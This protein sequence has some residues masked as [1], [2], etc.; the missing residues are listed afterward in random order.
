MAQGL[1][2]ADAV[3]LLG[4]AGPVLRT[5]D[6]L[7]GGALAVA[8]GGGSEVALSLFDAKAEVIRLG[9]VV[10]GKIQ[11]SVRVLGRYDR[12]SRLQAAHGVLV[13]SSFFEALDAT[14]RASAVEPPELTRADQIMLASDTRVDGSWLHMLFHADLPVPA[15]ESSYAELLAAL[16]GWYRSMARRVRAYLEGLAVWDRASDTDQRRAAEL[17]ENRVPALALR[18]YE[19]VHRQ[20]AVDVPEFGL[21]VAAAD[22]RRIGQSL[23]ELRE[24]LERATSGRDPSARR[25]G[26]AAAYRADLERSVAGDATGDLVAPALRDAYLDPRF[27]VK[28]AGPGDRVATDSWWDGDIRHDLAGFLARYLTTPQAAEAPL[29]LLGQ[30][31]AGKSALTRVLA[32]RLPAADFLAVRVVLREVPAEA[33][34]QDQIE[35]AVR[36]TIG[37]SIAWADL[38]RDAGDAMPLILLDGFDELLQATGIH[39]SDYLHRVAEFQRREAVQ[40]RPVAV[41]VTSRVA[42]GDRARVPAGS[43]AVRLEGFDESQVARWLLTWNAANAARPGHRDLLPEQVGRFPDFCEQP[44]LLLMLALYDATTYGLQ[45]DAA[46]GTTQLYER[47]LSSFAE[48]EVRRLHPGAPEHAVP[49]LV[50]EELVRLSVVAFSMFNRVRQSVTERQLD[51]DLRALGVGPVRPGGDEAFRRPLSGAEELIGRFF[52][53]Q[54]A[55]ALSDGQTLQTYEFL[56][57]TFGEFLVARLVVRL[58]RDTAARAAVMTLTLDGGVR[59]DGLLQAL[60][61]WTPLAARGTVLP[62]VTELLREQDLTAVRAWLLDALRAAVLRPAYPQREYRPTDRRLDHLTATYSLNLALLTLACGEPLR[63]SEVFVHAADPAY[64]LR[65]AA[66]Q[67][68]AAV[69][70]GIWSDLVDTMTVIRS[71]DGDRRDLVLDATSQRRFPAVDLAWTAAGAR[72]WTSV[73]YEQVANRLQLTGETSA[74]LLRLA[75]EPLGQWAPD[76]VTTVVPLGE[77]DA[78]TVAHC[79]TRVWVASARGP[80][81]LPAEYTRAVAVLF[82]G[83]PERAGRQLHFGR[84]AR[85]LL[86]MLARDAGRL[87]VG[88]VLSWLRLVSA[89]GYFRRSVPEVLECLA[90][91]HAPADSGVAQLIDGMDLLRLRLDITDQLRVVAA[92]HELREHLPESTLRLLRANLAPDAASRSRTGSPLAADRALAARVHRALDQ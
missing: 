62:F 47:L 39:Q 73:P 27:R 17:I 5:M 74:D 50:D 59:D 60:L 86:G 61:G 87:P 13:V 69:P 65:V 33:G 89:G 43:L 24:L 32:A 37:E 7:L 92:L 29:L 81:D 63:A 21:W 3:K 49:A 71:W 9:H 52:F 56:H 57:A 55:R 45:G 12:S 67:W 82:G 30:P 53:I 48:R 85:M 64:W 91:L 25:A 70:S 15:A 66:L 20:L 42:V 54:R 72:T 77:D 88:D 76:T 68:E 2:Y 22:R 80:D 40:G 28:A 6:D 16:D 34:I 51:A 18:R 8:T 44:L 83:G 4:G 26:L 41:M 84:A 46:F 78:D 58:V 1:R 36:A 31:G 11:D 79:L 75:L 14:V 90:A 23:T 10:A 19:E 35:V 38:A